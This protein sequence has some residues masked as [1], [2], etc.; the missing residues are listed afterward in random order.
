MRQTT[1]TAILA[2]GAAFLPLSAGAANL[3]IAAGSVGEDV[4]EM[5]AQLDRFQEETGHTVSIVE[6]PGSSTDQF[7]Q[8]RL[9]L[10]GVNEAPCPSSAGGGPA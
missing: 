5:R 2:A 7:A 10:S 8:Y 1:I 3:S 6:L 9:W 4:A